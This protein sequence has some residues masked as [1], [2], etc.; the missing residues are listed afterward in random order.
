MTTKVTRNWQ[1]I[2]I[3]LQAE[4]LLRASQAA[5]LVPSHGRRGHCSAN[6]IINWI[7]R[8]KNGIYLDGMRAAGKTWMTSKEALSRFFAQLSAKEAASRTGRKQA[9]YSDAEIRAEAARAEIMR[10]RRR[11]VARRAG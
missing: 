7:T 1:E 9:T 6:A 11:A 3:R 8:G 2:A 10:R 4:T 5:R